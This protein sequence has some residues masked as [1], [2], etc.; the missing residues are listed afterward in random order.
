MHSCNVALCSIGCIRTVDSK[1][2]AVLPADLTPN[3]QYRIRLTASD[4]NTASG[5][6]GTP[7]AA[8]QKAKARFASETV[9][10]D[11]VNNPKVTV[12][13]E[14]GGPWSYRFGT[15]NSV[16]NRQSYTPTDVIELFQASPSQYYRLFSVS[17]GCGNGI[18][19]SPST[20]R[21]E[22]ITATEP[23]APA[24]HV[25]V[26]PNPVQDL[27][28]VKSENNDEKIMQLIHQN[29]TVVRT[30]KTRRG[31]EQLDIRN[32]SPGIYL[33]HV[34]AKGRKATFKVIKQ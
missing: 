30:I 24:F 18:I 23:K 29:G 9:I 25:I 15:D 31:E 7:I 17:N 2:Q 19:E 20:V 33:L 22:V 12:L 3:A 6:Y 21:V 28:T 27:L 13:L 26:A 10:F 4:P 8:M 34:N 1:I 5:A 11:G 14:G 32:L 16:M